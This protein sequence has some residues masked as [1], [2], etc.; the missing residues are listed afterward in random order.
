MDY[1]YISRAN[2]RAWRGNDIHSMHPN[3]SHW[4]IIVITLIQRERERGWKVMEGCIIVETNSEL[5]Y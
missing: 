2:A 4:E 3:L 5:M 1:S